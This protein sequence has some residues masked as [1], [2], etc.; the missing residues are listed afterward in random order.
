MHCC[1]AHESCLSRMRLTRR[2]LRQMLSS[3]PSSI[4]TILADTPSLC[5]NSA[6]IIE[7]LDGLYKKVYSDSLARNQTDKLTGLG[8]DSAKQAWLDGEAN[9]RLMQSKAEQATQGAAFAA[10][11]YEKWAA[12]VASTEARLTTLQA[13]TAKE[14]ANINSEIA[15]IGSVTELI[16]TL[17]S[18]GSA[19][20]ASPVMMKDLRNKIQLLKAESKNVLKVSQLK[21]LDTKL[22]DLSAIDQVSP[23]CR[24]K[25]L[26]FMCQGGGGGG[27][28]E[29]AVVVV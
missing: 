23:P 19:A 13:D 2:L 20:K 27:G 11:K 8:A 12:T 24:P 22:A 5:A 18:G 14:T 10:D 3:S 9:Y 21:A 17:T 29:G 15:A 28:D 16:A 26:F 25:L 1:A 6:K 7:Q 4:N